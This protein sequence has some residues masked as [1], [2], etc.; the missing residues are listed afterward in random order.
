ML[1]VF[2][3][4]CLFVFLSFCLFVC[5]SVSLFVFL[6]VCL[7]VCL[8]NRPVPGV[9]GTLNT[10]CLIFKVRLDEI[11]CWCFCLALKCNNNHFIYLLSI[12]FVTELG[13]DFTIVKCL[14][15]CGPNQSWNLK[16]SK[17]SVEVSTGWYLSRSIFIF[18]QCYVSTVKK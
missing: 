7:F 5:L 3:S 9:G 15:L 10:N 6:S 4:V 14:F 8:E 12:S 18:R 2:L 1:F 16:H 11:M 17:L 13:V